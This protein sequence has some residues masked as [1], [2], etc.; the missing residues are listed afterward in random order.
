[1]S[2]LLAAGSAML[3]AAA[4][5][6]LAGAR[7]EATAG[8]LRNAGRSIAGRLP[9]TSAAV[10]RGLE[11]RLL[12]AGLDGRLEPRVVLAARLLTALVAVPIALSAAPM[13]PGRLGVLVALGVPAACLLAPDL[14]LEWLGRRR[15][16]RIQATLPATLD[17][18]AIGA[19]AGRG[20]PALV[21]DASRGAAGPLRR[22]LSGAVAAIECGTSQR[23]ALRRLARRGVPELAS[24][25]AA[26]ERSRRHGSPLAA[27][28]HE[29]ATSLRED[30][31]R[32]TEETAAR[33]A[34]KIQL[35][36]ALL[37]VPSVLLILAAAILAH[38]GAL[39][40]GL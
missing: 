3:L 27:G 38:S 14:A 31:R 15:R 21:A 1:V 25:V 24:L 36:V 10:T 26:L 29:Q 37:L 40:V 20:I 6:E 22:E 34:P 18:M 7:G 5:W 33:A 2:A 39:L 19:A 4:L 28:L 16:R 9:I 35:A 23:A 30:G 13:A 17:L 8:R 11:P 12:A 32:R